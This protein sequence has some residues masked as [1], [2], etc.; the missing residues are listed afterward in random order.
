MLTSNNK[1][2]IIKA[3]K[4]RNHGAE[5]SEEQRHKGPKPYL[6]PDFNFLGYNYRMTDI[7]GSVDIA[8]IKKQ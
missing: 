6:L 3:E 1:K 8:Q 7:Q 4:L 2:F 5:I